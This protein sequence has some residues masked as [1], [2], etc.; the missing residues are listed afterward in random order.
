MQSRNIS[1]K[2]RTP[3]A[4]QLSSPE[5]LRTIF[6]P[7]SLQK[8]LRRIA[9]RD[10]DDLI[11]HPLKSL[12]LTEYEEQITEQLVRSVPPGTWSPSGA[13]VSLT[14]KRSGAYRELVF[15]TLI[16]GIVGRCL[17]DAIEPLI[18]ADDEGKTFSGIFFRRLI[19]P[20][21]RP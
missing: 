17:V 18:T 19:E 2:T 21:Q 15:P 7:G 13:Y 5:V 1:G 3:T 16:D 20:G 8:A 14:S 6:S 4:E 10:K 9:A 11:S 12:V